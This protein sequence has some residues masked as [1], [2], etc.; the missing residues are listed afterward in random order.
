MAVS[1][2]I[3]AAILIILSRGARYGGEA[4]IYLNGEEYAR[5]P[6]DRADTLKIEQD[7]TAYADFTRELAKKGQGSYGEMMLC[8]AITNTL[9][10]FPEIKRVQILIEGKKAITLSGHMDIEDPLTRNTTLL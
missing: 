4:V 2:I 8:Y 6:L 5:M 1:A 10:E 7:G 9:T 3:I